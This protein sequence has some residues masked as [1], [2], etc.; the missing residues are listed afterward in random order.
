MPVGTVIVV[1]RRLA[2]G[3][4]LPESEHDLGAFCEHQ[5]WFISDFDTL[6]LFLTPFSASMMVRQTSCDC[7]G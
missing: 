1:E 6:S 7:N 3:L 4:A 5:G 2:P